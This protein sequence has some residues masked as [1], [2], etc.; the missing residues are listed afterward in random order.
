MK[1]LLQILTAF[2]LAIFGL[3]LSACTG[4]VA[5]LTPQQR[6]GLYGMAAALSGH[7][8]AVPVIYGVRRLTSAKDVYPVNPNPL[9]STGEN[10]GNGGLAPN[11]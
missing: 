11:F 5:G 7:P 4:N 2:T 9:N 8:E 3:H 10:G 1:R 6:N